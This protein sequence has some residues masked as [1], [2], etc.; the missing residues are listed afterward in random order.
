MDDLISR[1]KA[2]NAIEKLNWYHVGENGKLVCGAN[3]TYDK[4]LFRI[5]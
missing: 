2:I 4:P 5:I 1:E 3:S